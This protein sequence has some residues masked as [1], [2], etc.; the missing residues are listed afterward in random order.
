MFCS[1]S[2]PTV[3]VVTK[4]I[5]KFTPNTV[6]DS[7]YD[8]LKFSNYKVLFCYKLPFRINSVTTNKGSILAIIYFAIYFILLIVFLLKELLNSK[9]I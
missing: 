1:G 3:C 7:F 4:E 5:D 2:C 6:I 9:Y 8:T